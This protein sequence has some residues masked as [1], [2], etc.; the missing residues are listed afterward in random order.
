[1]I[2]EHCSSEFTY[3]VCH[4]PGVLHVIRVKPMPHSLGI[5]TLWVVTLVRPPSVP[6][7]QA[8]PQ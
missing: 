8:I 3:R 2:Q 5:G 4:Q 7:C 1:M 6:R